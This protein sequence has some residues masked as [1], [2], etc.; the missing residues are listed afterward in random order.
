MN[1]DS[2]SSHY[3][4]FILLGDFNVEPTEDAMEEFMKVYNLKNL[5][6]GP[7]CFENPGK[8]SCIDL[9]LSNKSKTFQT[10]QIIETGISDFHKMVMTVLKVYFKKKGP[11]IIQYG[12]YKN[13]SNDKFRNELNE[14]IRSKIE[15]SSLDIFV[16]AVLKVLSKNSPIKKRYIRANEAPFMNKVLKKAIMKSSQL[17]N[18]FLKKNLKVKLYIINKGST[19]SASYGKKNETTLKTLTLKN[20]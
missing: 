8:P 3:K 12:K 13:F 1:L 18:V 19:A 15:S 9:T 14:R 2:Y 17:R 20:F 4:N 7:T 11:S 16:S 6:K 10:S 5:V